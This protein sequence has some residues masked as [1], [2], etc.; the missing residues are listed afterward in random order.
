VEGGGQVLGYV[1]QGGGLS[2]VQVLN[3]G[4]LVVLDQPHLIDLIA[5]RS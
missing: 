3:A 5:P 2:W 4:H 1:Q